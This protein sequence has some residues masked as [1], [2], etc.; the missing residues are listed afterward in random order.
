MAVAD[1][2]VDYGETGTADYAV[3]VV[4]VGSGTFTSG[5]G[6]LYE[7]IMFAVVVAVMMPNVMIMVGRG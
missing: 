4:A 1:V 2:V 5:E 6:G 7:N 3:A